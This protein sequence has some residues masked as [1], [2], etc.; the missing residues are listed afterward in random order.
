MKQQPEEPPCRNGYAHDFVPLGVE[1]NG[2]KVS[3]CGS[4]MTL[5]YEAENGGVR[6]ESHG[7]RA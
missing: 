2:E 7:P 4:C 1:D 5:K 3:R 6:Y